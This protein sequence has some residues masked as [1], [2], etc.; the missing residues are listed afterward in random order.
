MGFHHVDQDGLDLLTCDPPA[1][2]CQSAGITG[3]SHHAR[4]KNHIL[5][6]EKQANDDSP[7]INELL[8]LSDKDFKELL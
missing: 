3:L 2:A 5:N 6:E 1:S 7:K 8:K 4:P